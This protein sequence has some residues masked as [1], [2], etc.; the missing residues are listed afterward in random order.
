MTAPRYEGTEIDLKS[1]IRD[2][3]NF[4]T[5]GILFRD[6]TPLL[7]TPVAFKYVVD[8][9]VE[10]YA[11]IPVDVVVAIEARGFLFGTPLAYAL[12]KPLVPVRKE[13]KLPA[14]T[15]GVEYSLEYG[16]N[17]VEIHKDGI[18]PGQ[19]VVVVD[20]LLAT[21][22]TLAAAVQLVEQAGGRV[23]SLAMVIELTGLEGRSLLQ[24][25][26]VFTLVQY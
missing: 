15:M 2:I 10:R 11:D 22:G 9:F 17:V 20:D 12:G 21:G 6:I 13:G 26:D 23:E 4:P 8:R 5:P 14:E 19:R 1:Y 18:S 25:Y 3:P 24:G 16:T 7:Q